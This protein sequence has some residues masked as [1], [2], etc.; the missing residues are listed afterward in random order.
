MK[1]NN[2]CID[3]GKKISKGH[4]RCSY[5]AKLGK[6]GP[7]YKNGNYCKDKKYYCIDCGKEI[8]RQSALYGQGRCKSCANKNINNPFFG[9]IHTKKTYI[10]MSLSHGGTG[11]PYEHSEYGS[12]FDSSL[13]EQVRF[14]DKYKCQI[15]GCSQLEN[16]RQLDVHHID[17]HKKNNKLNNL[18]AL[19]KSCHM[20][21]NYNRK[22]WKNYFKN[23]EAINV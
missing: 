11:I 18:I 23:M 17:Y 14:R 12:E 22:N 9:K 10:K 4:K 3:C 6:K 13:K 20:K 2:H 8:T 15:C 19:C 5:C 16:G 7:N 21:T 1:K